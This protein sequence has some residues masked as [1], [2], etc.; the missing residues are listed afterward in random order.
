MNKKINVGVIFGGKSGEHEVSL[1][2]SYNVIKAI[3]KDRYEIT[4]IGITKEGEWK[5]YCGDVEAIKEGTWELQTEYI[6]TDF[7]VFKDDT[8]GAVDIFFPV[9]H[10]TF[11]EDGTIQG[12]FEMLDKPY[13]GCGV[14]ASAVAM[15]KAIA[16][17]LFT[18]ESIPVVEGITFNRSDVKKIDACVELLESKF[19]YP[20]FVKPA[21]M[22]SS[23]GISKAHDRIEFQN[24]IAEAAKYDNKILAEKFISAKEIEVAVL[25]NDEPQASCV[26]HIIPCNEFYDYEAKY[27]SGDDSKIVI[28]APLSE[29]LTEQIKQYA[30]QAFKVIGGSGLSRVDFFVEEGTDNIYLNEINTMPGFTNISMYSKLWDA[31]GIAYG[32][33]VE[34]LIELGFE[35]Y[36]SRKALLYK[37]EF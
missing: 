34:K 9:M 7:S 29:R 28:P 16:K 31:S 14:A 24:A 22:G 20:V 25:G 17:I 30:I 18:S 6:R 13:V 33:L 36:N 12:F 3:N 15:D 5:L 19:A 4:M 32:E 8:F 10:G 27:L 1:N 2:S 37:K 11:G 23:V 35:R 21:N 26:G